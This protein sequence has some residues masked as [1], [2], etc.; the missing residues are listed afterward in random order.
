MFY[1]NYQPLNKKIDNIVIIYTHELK[2]SCYFMINN[3]K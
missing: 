2:N 3:V 1:Q